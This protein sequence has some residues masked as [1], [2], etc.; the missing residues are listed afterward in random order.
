[1]RLKEVVYSGFVA[2]SHVS[3]EAPRVSTTFAVSWVRVQ[4]MLQVLRSIKS[5]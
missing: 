1:M 2:K 4:Q 5:I 3:L